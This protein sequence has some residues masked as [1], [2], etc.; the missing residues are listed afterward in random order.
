MPRKSRI[1]TRS[2][3]DTRPTHHER[4][5]KCKST[6]LLS[7]QDMMASQRSHRIRGATITLVG[8]CWSN[9]EASGQEMK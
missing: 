1:V 9:R 6:A 7:A 3:G 4:A 2:R 5:P 8:A